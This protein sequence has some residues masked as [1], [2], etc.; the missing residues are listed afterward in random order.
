M[1]FSLTFGDTGALFGMFNRFFG[2]LDQYWRMTGLAMTDRRIGML[3][4]L[5]MMI[6]GGQSGTGQERKN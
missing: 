5:G 1:G 6:F 4:S 3:N 2:M